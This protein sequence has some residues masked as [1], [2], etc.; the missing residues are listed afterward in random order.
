[1]GGPADLFKHTGSNADPILD[2]AAARGGAPHRCTKPDAPAS[3][4]ST[5]ARSA[6]WSRVWH[7]IWSKNLSESRLPFD[8][9]P[10]TT[11]SCASRRPSCS[12]GS[13]DCCTEFSHHVSPPMKWPLNSSYRP[14]AARFRRASRGRTTGPARPPA[15]A[16]GAAQ[17]Q[18][19]ADRR[20]LPQSDVRFDR[21]F[22]SLYVIWVTICSSLY[23]IWVTIGHVPDSN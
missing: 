18:A 12:A 16:R 19:T 4:R 21:I 8:D 3:P 10:P 11:P 22:S 23:V 13:K 15:L 17:T 9:E 5:V 7:R 6:S 2:Q 14:C 1:M 20:G